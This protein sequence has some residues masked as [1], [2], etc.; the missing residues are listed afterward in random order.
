MCSAT[1]IFLR[2][3]KSCHVEHPSYYDNDQHGYALENIRESSLY[4]QQST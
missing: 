1:C 3:L 2:G 4:H